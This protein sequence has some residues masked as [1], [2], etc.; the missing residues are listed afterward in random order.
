[1]RKPAGDKENVEPRKQ[2]G[3]SNRA[4]TKDASNMVHQNNNRA[5]PTS[6]APG[7]SA[8]PMVFMM[9][10]NYGPMPT[11]CYK[12]YMGQCDGNHEFH[13]PTRNEALDQIVNDT[14]G[15]MESG[16]LA[17]SFESAGSGEG[18]EG[19]IGNT[20]EGFLTALCCNEVGGTPA[21]RIALGPHRRADSDLLE[22]SDAKNVPKVIAIESDQ[23][24]CTTLGVS[25]NRTTD[26][27]H[28]M[29]STAQET[30]YESETTDDG[31]SVDL[32]KA[33]E[34]AK[35]EQLQFTQRD[36]SNLL[37]ESLEEENHKATEILSKHEGVPEEI[38]RMANEAEVQKRKNI[39]I[40]A[41][42]K[43][44]LEIEKRKANETVATYKKCIESEKQKAIATIARY[45]AL[46]S[47]A[48]VNRD[49]ARLQ[50][51]KERAA[52]QSL[53]AK[54]AKT[55]DDLEKEKQNVNETSR[56]HLATVAKMEERIVAA[57][58]ARDTARRQL[59]NQRLLSSDTEDFTFSLMSENDGL[60]SNLEKA[61]KNIALLEVQHKEEAAKLKSENDDLKTQIEKVA[62]RCTTIALEL[63]NVTA[64]KEKISTERS[65]VEAKLKGTKTILE[66]KMEEAHS[67]NA[68]IGK[69]TAEVSMLT[70]E[71]DELSTKLKKS[72]SDLANVRKHAEG[73]KLAFSQCDASRVKQ[74]RGLEERLEEERQNS[75]QTSM[76]LSST[77]AQLEQRI[78]IAQSDLER[79][80]A[81]MKLFRV[82]LCEAQGEASLRKIECDEIKKSQVQSLQ[83]FE[84]R[85][86]SSNGMLECAR[87][88]QMFLREQ[89]VVFENE[90]EAHKEETVNLKATIKCLQTERSKLIEHIKILEVKMPKER[91]TEKKMD[92]QSLSDWITSYQ[93]SSDK[94]CSV[95]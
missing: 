74:I 47:T 44:C 57:E 23:N 18:V 24:D 49:Q 65:N 5:M 68:Q 75:L 71:R 76:D 4:A 58:S 28:T 94:R 72:A 1:L 81:E 56:D 7:N 51:E 31:P 55:K 46:I 66:Q 61:K 85:L 40:V 39:E 59:D 82:Q 62:A 30:T 90:G 84:S 50:L 69:L 37:E 2:A 26:D 70:Q 21:D 78:S 42:Y 32:V 63:E 25:M 15:S 35:E 10:A 3:V 91:A 73:E 20:L 6:M 83:D 89:L 93:K 41:A 77:I 14:F 38:K 95:D 86:Q 11:S 27:L 13:I 52:S 80:R 45:E 79:E 29:N 92:I 33:K 22:D 8:P 87:T 36:A 43:K 60:A 48:Q 12:C 19:L 16:E 54:L 64:E 9:P 17:N 53:K 88:E 34:Y 67:L